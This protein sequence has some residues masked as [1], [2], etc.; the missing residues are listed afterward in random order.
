MH[1]QGRA[2]CTMHIMRMGCIFGEY[3][4]NVAHL[5]R[6]AVLKRDGAW[7]LRSTNDG[8]SGDNNSTDTW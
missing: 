7:L 5:L 1:Q 8:D 6:F 3:K 2:H 4:Q